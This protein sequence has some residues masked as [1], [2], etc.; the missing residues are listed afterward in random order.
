LT[1]TP[2]TI[3]PSEKDGLP[4]PLGTGDYVGQYGILHLIVAILRLRP[5]PD[6]DKGWLAELHEALMDQVNNLKGG[7]WAVKKTK[8]EIEM[9][10]KGSCGV[11]KVRIYDTDER[12]RRIE[13]EPYICEDCHKIISGTECEDC[14][15]LFTCPYGLNPEEV[16]CR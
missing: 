1:P 2:T 15:D 4:E 5:H 7:A 3:T 10:L 9:E 11:C 8:E 16:G 14:S 12:Y 13:G 6:E